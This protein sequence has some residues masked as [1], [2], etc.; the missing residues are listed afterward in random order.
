VRLDESE[1][2]LIPE[3][4]LQTRIRELA[5][6]IADDYR[7]KDLLLLGCSRARSCSWST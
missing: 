1:E 5:A 6:C 7:G 2:V 4:A 3:A